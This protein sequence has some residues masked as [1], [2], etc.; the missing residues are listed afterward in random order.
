M[1]KIVSYEQVID[2]VGDIRNLR[3]GYATNFFWDEQKHPYWILDNSFF[4]EKYD[5]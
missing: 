3:Q 1:D 4:Y 2:F 5:G